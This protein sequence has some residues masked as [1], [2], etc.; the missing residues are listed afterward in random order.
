MARN[1]S[2]DDQVE[3]KDDSAAVAVEANGEEAEDQPLSLDVQ[4]TNPSACER[5][6]IAD[7][8]RDAGRKCEVEAARRF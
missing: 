1:Q 3:E 7:A 5:H 2:D 8:G 6:V 4:V